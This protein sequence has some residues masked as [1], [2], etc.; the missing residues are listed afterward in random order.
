MDSYTKSTLPSR[1]IDT[2]TRKTKRDSKGEGKR[3]LRLY[4][5][6]IID[7]SYKNETRRLA[8]LA[9]KK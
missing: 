4:S 8:A 7:K 3:D 2:I 9:I 1:A 6:K 5:I